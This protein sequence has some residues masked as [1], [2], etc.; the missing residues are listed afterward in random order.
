M[1]LCVS[2]VF[3]RMNIPQFVYSPIVG[4][5]GCFQFLAIVK[6]KTVSVHSYTSLFHKDICSFC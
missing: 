3:H 2:V 4:H 6:N 1:W 5:L